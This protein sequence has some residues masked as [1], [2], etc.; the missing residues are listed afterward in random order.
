MTL[1]NDNGTDGQTDRQSATQYAAPSYGGGRTIKDQSPS[2]SHTSVQYSCSLRSVG[3]HCL[4]VYRQQLYIAIDSF[5]RAT[6]CVSAV[7]AVTR[8]VFPSILLFVTFVC[9]IQTAEHHQ[10]SFSSR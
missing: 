7:F 1:G 10:T 2:H 5:Y 6:L 3:V 4:Y 8:R 9:C